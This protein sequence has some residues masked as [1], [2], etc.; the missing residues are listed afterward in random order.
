VDIFF[1]VVKDIV[2]GEEVQ[3]VNELRARIV[4]AAE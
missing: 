2:N 1:W 4:R 3:N